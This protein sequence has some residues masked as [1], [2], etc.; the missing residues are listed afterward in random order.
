MLVR[1]PYIYRPIS[2]QTVYPKMCLKD[3]WKIL[4]WKTKPTKAFGEEGG[5]GTSKPLLL[6]CMQG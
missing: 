5:G 6:R 4:S 1:R 3:N 2:H